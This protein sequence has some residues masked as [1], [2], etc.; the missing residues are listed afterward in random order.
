[1]KALSAALEKQPITLIQGPPGTGK[2]R[3]ILSLLSVILHAQPGAKSGVE[4][5]LKRYL[6]VRNK[7]ALSP[8]DIVN[9]HRRSAPWLRGVL[10]PR[11]APPLPRQAPRPAA[12][13]VEKPEV[14]GEDSVRRT[15]VLI[16]A[17]SNAALDEIVLRILKTGVFGPNGSP[18]SPTLVRV[19]VKV[20]HS[21]EAVGMDALVASRMNGREE[22]SGMNKEKKFELA[23]ERD[24]V[25][26]AI[27]DEAAVVCSTL[28]FSGS[29]MFSRMTRQFDVVVIDEASQAVEP[30]TLVPLC[31]GAK[32]VFL[33]GDPQQ[34]PATVL[35]SVATDHHYDQS[36]FK[37]FEQC[38]YPIHMLKTQYRMHPAIREFPSNQFYAGELEDGESQAEKTKKPWH[39]NA[40]FRPFVFLDIDGK[41]YHGNGA[42][43]AN[44]EEADV[45]VNLVATLMRTY[46]ELA[47][48]EKIGV[49]SPYAA[50]VKLITRKLQDALGSERAMTVDVNSI[51]GFQGR[52]KSVCIFSVVRAPKHGG[53]IGFVK[54]E[55]RMNVGLTRAKN[56]LIVL[57]SAKS[58]KSDKNWGEL[59]NSA[60]KRG[61]IMK[62]P[63]KDHKAFVAKYCAAYN[64]D[65]LS[66][67]EEE[68]A[69]FGIDVETAKEKD[70]DAFENEN[71]GFVYRANWSAGQDAE[72][73]EAAAE[74]AAEGVSIAAAG[75]TAAGDDVELVTEAPTKGGGKDDY[76][77]GGGENDDD[78]YAQEPEVAAGGKKRGR[79][80]GGGG[81]V[82]K[83]ART[84]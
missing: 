62:P 52:E 29:G 3:V 21:V 1:M 74:A 12:P 24:R 81:G 25:K 56:S 32:Q 4:L 38:G 11:D 39:K 83:M 30:S 34:L 82:S 43:W 7:K 8:A 78:P 76:G 64:E 44:D 2:T 63:G 57:G 27:L 73:A 9:I 18:Y 37:R 46:P 6:E 15:K 16:C 36:L 13:P 22:K 69:D 50:Q 10:N 47:T 33:V 5:D 20:H 67:S 55:R 31:Y 58:L 45:A 79:P 60:K 66:G 54:D 28:S 65:D 75:F 35:S 71:G 48:G 26:L 49:I 53:S 40:L 61:L 70:G 84:R 59:V 41:E 80:G 51:D 42:S 77:D 19:G 23:L 14:L 72:E 68:E 17:P